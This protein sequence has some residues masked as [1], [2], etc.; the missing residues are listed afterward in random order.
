[1]A[2][3][4]AAGCVTI[5]KLLLA[6]TRLRMG[7]KMLLCTIA[8]VA[9]PDR[10]ANYTHNQLAR[11]LHVSRTTIGHW[12]T[13]LEALGY[14]HIQRLRPPLA[15]CQV[16]FVY[17]FPQRIWRL[18]LRAWSM[19]GPKF[20]KFSKAVLDWL[21]PRLP[22]GLLSI[23]FTDAKDGPAGQPGKHYKTHLPKELV[24]GGTPAPDYG[25]QLSL[26]GLA[27]LEPAGRFM[28]GLQKGLHFLSAERRAQVLA[29]VG[30]P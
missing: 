7:E 12:L 3:Q 28:D 17:L 15:R 24:R 9:T 21:E 6:D 1:M 23:P 22:L 18:F 11:E 13:K 25:E 10:P 20:R 8:A 19:A 30:I 5:P 2:K 29:Q 4:I 14:L 16:R 27:D 26:A